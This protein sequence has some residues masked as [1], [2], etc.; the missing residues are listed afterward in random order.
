M[1]VDFYTNLG[2][3]Q[4]AET[5]KKRE[6]IQ[7]V[8][9]EAARPCVIAALS[10]KNNNPLA[11]VAPNPQRAIRLKEEIDFWL[12]REACI[13]L[14]E[15]ES[16]L[17]QRLPENRLNAQERIEALGKIISIRSNDAQPVIILTAK[18]LA[19]KTVEHGK[20]VDCWINIKTGQQI[21]PIIIIQHLQKI[22]YNI[23]SMVNV[24]GTISRRG[25]IIDVFPVGKDKPVRIDFFGDEVDEIREFDPLSQRS[26]RTIDDVSIGPGSETS[27]ALFTYDKEI[28]NRLDAL[29]LTN[30]DE[31]HRADTFADINKLVS[32]EYFPHISYYGPLLYSESILNYLPA[33]TILIFDDI[34]SIQWTISNIGAED[35]KTRQTYVENGLLPGGMPSSYFNWQEIESQV[36]IMPSLFI[37]SWEPEAI[38][39][40]IRSGFN[41]VEKYGGSYDRFKTEI[42]KLAKE[43]KRVLV[44]SHQADRIR[45]I[46]NE[47]EIISS[48]ADDNSG[49]LLPGQILLV[50]GIVD[51]GW[52]LNGEIF[53]Y[54]DSEILGF[55]RQNRQVIKKPG[56][57]TISIDRIKPGDFVVH[58]DHGIARFGGITNMQ[59]EGIM[60]EFLVL[61]YDGQ[62]HLYVPVDQI[63]RVSRYIGSGDTPPPL[64]RL[65]TGHWQNSREKATEAAKEIAA[66]LLSLY[67]QREIIKGFSYSE[68]SVWQ[69][70]LE[71][72]FP[73]VETPDQ[74]TA[75]EQI[76]TD[77]SRTRPMDR[78]LLGDVGYG[79][80]EVAIR[81]AFKAVQDNRQVAVL[82]PTTLLA[83]QHYIT[84]SQRLAAYPV[85]IESLSRFKTSGEQTNIISRLKEGGIDIIIGTHRLLQKDVKFK[86]LG[87]IIIDEEQRFGVQHKEYL[88]KKRTEVDVLAMSATPIPRTLYMS[89]TGV[90]DISTIETPPEERLPVHTMVVRYNP[91]LIREAIMREVERNG[92]VFFVHNRVQSI[93]EINRKL[94]EIVPE[95]R[96]SLAHGQM[97]EDELAQVMLDFTSGKT[98]VLICTTIIESGLDV[99]NANT[100]IV[101]R[102]DKFGLIQLH[103]LRGRV[104][105]GTA[106]G[107]AYFVYDDE[108]KLT[109]DGR[110][111]LRTIYELAQLGSGFDIAMKDLEIRGAGTLLGTH[112]SGHIA[113][114]GFNMYTELLKQAVEEEKARR[115]GI[116]NKKEKKLPSPKINLPLV[117]LIPDYYVPDNGERLN[118]YRRISGIDNLKD[119]ED[120]TSELVDRFGALP[121]ESANLI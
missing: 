65:G 115:A 40:I 62:D 8:I 12:G 110:R 116:A 48:L 55:T 121:E 71:D 54:S 117:M 69:R 26:T 104:G 11:V 4:I 68:D 18:T 107:Y 29:Q 58:V 112:Q 82:V 16:L 78:L 114:V 99:P 92:Q 90:R 46:L 13:V 3:E 94:K 47:G 52:N 61:E 111:R 7:A 89:M 77:M 25:G 100:L 36:N 80:T 75:L 34:D 31:E 101:N 44:V 109:E 20:F 35:Y 32:G 1:I 56:K 79:K 6:Q 63:D 50:K 98:D 38:G 66:E 17:Y 21:D 119:L 106:A 41:P 14:P 5:L 64:N 85:T 73:Y 67:S 95:A 23:E 91:Q 10:V 19:A 24:P 74:L 108:E 39:G 59:S 105:R 118:F 93:G 72:S 88:K 87:L 43:G 102:A 120:Y 84:F 97:D 15:N 2:L 60:R 9:M 113:A 57:H 42:V 22:G 83:Q 76:K 30:L 86:N 81:A 70:E 28:K 37:Y 49:H 96:F 103:Q 51:G 27:A 33:N 53:L 45:D